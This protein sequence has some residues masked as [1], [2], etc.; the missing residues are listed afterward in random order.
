MNNDKQH[1]YST[2]IKKYLIDINRINSGINS[3][4]HYKYYAHLLL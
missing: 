3:E 4:V 1:D 2:Y